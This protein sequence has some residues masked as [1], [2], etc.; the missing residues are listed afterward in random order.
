MQW[1]QTTDYDTSS[2]YFELQ[3][4]LLGSHNDWVMTTLITVGGFCEGKIAYHCPQTND[5]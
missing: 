5:A 3:P 4:T 2:C 1:C